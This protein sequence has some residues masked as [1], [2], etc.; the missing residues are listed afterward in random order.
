MKMVGLKFMLVNG[1]FVAIVLSEEEAL[2]FA[3]DWEDISLPPVISESYF[4]TVVGSP[5]VRF[6]AE[7][8]VGCHTFELDQLQQGQ[9]QQQLQQQAKGTKHLPHQ[10]FVQGSGIFS[11]S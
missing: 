4:K 11:R 10:G 6:R 1:H 3:Q 8:V 5:C 9:A 7:T 2:K